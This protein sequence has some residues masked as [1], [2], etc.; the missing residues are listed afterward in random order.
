[1]KT[2]IALALTFFAS[3]SFANLAKVVCHTTSTSSDSNVYKVIVPVALEDENAGI[4]YCI[5]NQDLQIYKNQRLLTTI[6]S[7]SCYFKSQGN[8][9]K[10]LA[11]VV[12]NDGLDEV[13][14]VEYNMN[15][16]KH[17]LLQGMVFSKGQ[18]FV[19]TNQ[20]TC[21]IVK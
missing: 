9:V 18:S 2:I 14:R 1:M 21:E 8:N 19:K 3:Y 10:I 13:I 4:D 16:K 17:S 12:Y 6:P 11:L 7:G 20:V 15:A 5:T